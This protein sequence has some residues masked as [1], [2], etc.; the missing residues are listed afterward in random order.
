MTGALLDEHLQ[1]EL[2]VV[3]PAYNEENG[4]GPTLRELVA[5]LPFVEVIVVDDGSHDGT[6]D[7]AL[8]VEGVRVLS[9]R[10]NR[11]YGA[12]LK[13]GMRASRRAYVAWFDADNEHRVSDLAAMAERIQK[14]DLSAVIGS[15]I[16]PAVSVVRATGKLVIR[17]MARTLGVDLGNDLNCGLRIFRRDVITPYLGIL[18]DQF[19]ASM[20]S[21]MVL[22]EQGRRIAFHDIEVKRRIGH[23]KVRMRDGFATMVLVLRFV[24]LFAPIRMLFVPGVL[25]FVTGVVYGIVRAA[26]DGRGIPVAAVLASS[27]G[28]SVAVLGLV[29]DQ[30]SQMRLCQLSEGAA[31]AIEVARPKALPS[32]PPR[33]HDDRPREALDDG[34]VGDAI[35]DPHDPAHHPRE[36]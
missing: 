36:R 17:L 9:H 27:S 6:R 12:A 19:S 24:M 15:R 5:S 21:T 8:E 26:L 32:A 14:E 28:L 10:F 7:R 22:V 18:P 34:Q 31:D 16:T 20:T 11:G 29:A 30:I 1:R 25:L 13:T 2:S 23:S 3:I 4:I 33:A 35:V